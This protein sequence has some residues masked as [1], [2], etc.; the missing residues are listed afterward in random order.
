M[1]S[2]DEFIQIL[3]NMEVKDILSIISSSREYFDNRVQII[4]DVYS[5]RY[6][7]LSR[8]G[9]YHFGLEPTEFNLLYVDRVWE[10][11][12]DSSLSMNRILEQLSLLDLD[13][14]GPLQERYNRIDK[15]SLVVG[16]IQRTYDSLFSLLRDHLWNNYPHVETHTQ[17]DDD[18]YVEDNDNIFTDDEDFDRFVHAMIEHG[19]EWYSS[20]LLS[21]NPFDNIDE[22]DIEERANGFEIEEHDYPTNAGL[23][24]GD[25][26]YDMIKNDMEYNSDH[27]EDDEY[28]D[29]TPD[30]IYDGHKVCDEYDEIVS[31]IHGSGGDPSTYENEH[32]S[33][34]EE[35]DDILDENNIL[36]VLDRLKDNEIL[37]DEVMDDIRQH[38]HS[39]SDSLNNKELRDIILSLRTK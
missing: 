25:I 7:E 8:G 39:L 11:L 9:V 36:T 33:L 32:E 28:D 5:V 3:S 6:P 24:V 34:M 1:S 10:I 29:I 27:D 18:E 4:K 21:N 16:R 37:Y 35:V 26:D 15:F 17:M 12:H 19:R 20:L 30:I 31:N 23:S 14:Y 22:D 38:I 13:E 2:Y